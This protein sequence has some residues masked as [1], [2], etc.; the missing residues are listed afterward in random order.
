MSWEAYS[1]SLVAQGHTDGAAVCGYPDGAV[2][3]ATNLTLVGNEGK[4]LADRF[5]TPNNGQKLIAGDRKFMA[6]NCN[7]EFLTG[8]LANDGICVTKSGKCMIISVYKEGQIPGN[9]LQ[10]STAMTADLASKGF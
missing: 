5:A 1:Q 8:R 9:C 10:H 4:V 2:W 3:G 6:L 7:P